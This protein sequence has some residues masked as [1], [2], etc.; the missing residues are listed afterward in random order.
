MASTHGPFSF[1]MEIL[2]VPFLVLFCL[3][4]V[5]LF[6]VHA[7]SLSSMCLFFYRLH[8]TVATSLIHT[9][10]DYC[11]S[12]FLNHLLINLNVSNSF[13]IKLFVLSLK[14][15]NSLTLLLFLNLYIGSK[16]ISELTSKLCLSHISSSV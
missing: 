8:S 14:H 7:H 15:L 4:Y 10:L 9:R 1:S 3:F 11:K 6:L 5:L 13:L 12:L 2:K 16:L